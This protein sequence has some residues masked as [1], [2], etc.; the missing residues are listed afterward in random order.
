MVPPKF[1]GPPGTALLRSR[2]GWR[3]TAA[4]EYVPVAQPLRANKARSG[5]ARRDVRKPGRAAL[6]DSRATD[7]V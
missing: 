7:F 4:T 6:L 2:L 5:S 3:A 1:R